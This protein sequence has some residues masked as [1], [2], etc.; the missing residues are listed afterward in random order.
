MTHMTLFFVGLSSLDSGADPLGV[1]SQRPRVNS[2]IRMGDVCGCHTVD[3]HGHS[4]LPDPFWHPA[5]PPLCALATDGRDG[6]GR[7]GLGRRKGDKLN[8]FF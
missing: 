6:E 3:H 4:L 8:K 1:D 5:T 7:G 2:C